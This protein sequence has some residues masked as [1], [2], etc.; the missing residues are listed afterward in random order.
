M[1]IWHPSLPLI[2]KTTGQDTG[3]LLVCVVPLCEVEQGSP[4]FGGRGQI[5]LSR[6]R[7][8]FGFFL[9]KLNSF[10]ESINVASGWGSLVNG[11]H[12]TIWKLQIREWAIYWWLC[13]MGHI[14]A[15]DRR[16]LFTSIFGRSMQKCPWRNN[17]L[18]F[19]LKFHLLPI[20]YLPTLIYLFRFISLIDLFTWNIFL[21]YYIIN[22]YYHYYLFMD[23]A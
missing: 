22:N 5:Q 21:S 8:D 10:V 15:F 12:F 19:L 3:L 2:L 4:S 23:L 18:T 17:S 9:S 20:I 7:V 14:L 1:H 6:A 11:S 16:I 13:R